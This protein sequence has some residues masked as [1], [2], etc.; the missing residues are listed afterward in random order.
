MNG[1]SSGDHVGCAFIFASL[2]QSFRVLTF[3]VFEKLRSIVV[4]QKT[5]SGLN[6]EATQCNRARRFILN[7]KSVSRFN[8]AGPFGADKL[9]F[10]PERSGA[11]SSSANTIA[12]RT[13]LCG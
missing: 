11:S 1:S 3:C 4:A 5:N 13:G 12:D 6:I 7:T 2:R 10:K 8:T 9:A